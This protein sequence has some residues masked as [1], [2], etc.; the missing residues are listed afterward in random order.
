MAWGQRRLGHL[1]RLEA[2]LQRRVLLD[3]LAVFIER[4]RTDGL[5]LTAR[6]HGLEDRRR[7]DRALGRA[8]TDEG[9]DLVDEQDDV[10]PGADLLEYLLQALL[11]VTA[12]AGA[13]D[14]RPE[15]ERVK[16]LVLQGLGHV[17][18]HDVLGQTLDHGRLADAGLTDQDRVVLGAAREHLH[19]ALDLLLAPD[20]RVELGLARGL[21]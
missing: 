18:A 6:Q 10:A 14:Q 9:V 3:V 7:V 1:D 17:T 13:S 11:E 15:V 19:H 20:H 16:L 4:R 21:S 5:Q 12:V 8:R 2:A